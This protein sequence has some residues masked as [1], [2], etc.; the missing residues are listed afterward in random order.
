MV[1]LAIVRV[2]RHR[3]SELFLRDGLWELLHVIA[4]PEAYDYWRAMLLID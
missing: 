1:K 4:L 2:A 3:I